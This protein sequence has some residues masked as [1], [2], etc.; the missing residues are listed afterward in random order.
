MTLATFFKKFDSFADAPD[1]VTRMR[2]LLIHFAVTGKLV[3]NDLKEKP[4]ELKLSGAT[5]GETLLPVNWR[6]GFLG[7]A[8]NFEYGDNLPAPKRSQTGE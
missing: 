8:F 6:A 1:A 2:E 4:V 7:D 5:E 3:P